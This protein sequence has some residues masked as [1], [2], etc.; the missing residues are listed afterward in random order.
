[1]HRTQIEK[2][3]N[4]SKDFS[5]FFFLFLLFSQLDMWDETWVQSKQPEIIQQYQ[6]MMADKLPISCICAV[7][8]TAK[9][10]QDFWRSPK[11]P[12]RNQLHQDDEKHAQH[13]K[14]CELSRL[15][16]DAMREARISAATATPAKPRDKQAAAP[17]RTAPKA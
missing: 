8:T 3:K 14:Q 9:R 10:F 5:V 15:H 13:D 1:M 12:K 11:Q 17:R 16:G 6:R 2:K 7:R 4:N